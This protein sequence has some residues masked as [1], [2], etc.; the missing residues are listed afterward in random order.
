MNVMES[1]SLKGKVALVTGGAG[2]YGRQIVA[3]VAEA[4]AK[5]FV[6]S[7]N[8]A[9]LE[10]VAEQERARDLDVTALQFDLAEE[11][12]ILALRDTIYD[13]AGQLDV[14]V[15]NSVLRPMK[16][17]TDPV[18]TWKA[19]MEVNAT[20]L[21][22]ITR[23][24]AEKMGEAGRGSIINIS[25]IY[26]M[27]GPDYWLYEEVDW[28]QPPDYFFHKAGMINFARYVAAH[29]GARGVRC[30]TISPG[31]YFTG[32]EPGFLW[33]YEKSTCLGRMAGDD[34]LKG[35]IVFLASDAAAYIT[36]VNLPVDAG[37]TCK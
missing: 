16:G 8:L 36:G 29:Y 24:F 9:A 5:T 21:F 2:L 14:L 30:N 6:A 23:A 10:E 27:V 28:T 4:G 34:D 31:G 17:W 3:G 15:N 26:G 20:G 11:E 18:E 32:Q 12:S 1:F 19:S 13:R 22:L 7:R 25:S 35:A 33:R 37:R